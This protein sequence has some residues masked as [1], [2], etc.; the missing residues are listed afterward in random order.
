VAIPV[1]LF[2]CVH[3]SAAADSAGAQ[4]KVKVAFIGDS[5]SDGLWGG[6]TSI[7]SRQKCLKDVFELG[8]F[9]R[10]STGLTR[11]D[12]LDWAQEATKIASAYKPDIV[13]ISI[14]LN[15]RQPIVEPLSGGGRRVT[16]YE[17]PDWTQR[18]KIHVLELISKA[19]AGNAHVLWVGLP[20]MRDQAT[21]RD[22]RQKNQI[23]SEAVTETAA[24]NIHYIPP[25]RLVETGDDV[26]SS[27][28]RDNRGRMIHIRTPDGQH[29]TSEG[30]DL[31][32]AYLL[33]K[34][35]ENLDVRGA[36][37]FKSCGNTSP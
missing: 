20:V 22:A 17:T 16:A 24:A 28:T 8:R 18:Y 29:F 37:M 27:Y 21:D 36:N 34:I 10:I 2:F 13:I 6:I 3:C 9:G 31:V 11:I 32:A 19:S 25:W 12:R 23:F 15:D 4:G 33:P 26:F 1:W 5:T 7:V 14:G 35:V 30:N